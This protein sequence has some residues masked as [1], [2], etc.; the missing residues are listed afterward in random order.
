MKK[1]SIYILI[2]VFLFSGIFNV[3]AYAGEDI[4]NLE[5]DVS[6][7]EITAYVGDEDNNAVNP[8][9]TNI[10]TDDEMILYTENVN[11]DA[12]R[13][14][15]IN[16]SEDET[17]EDTL[18]L[19]PN[20][21][22]FLDMW[23]IYNSL[24]KFDY[25]NGTWNSYE[26]RI[27]TIISQYGEPD[28]EQYRTDA[29]DITDTELNNVTTYYNRLALIPDLTYTPVNLEDGYYL[30]PLI[31]SSSG[32]TI[33]DHFST[34]MLQK[35]ALVR[36]H[37]GEVFVTLRIG[38]ADCVAGVYVG[39]QAC[40]RLAKGNRTPNLGDANI[41]EG[42]DADIYEAWRAAGH[43][44]SAN[45]VYWNRNVTT[46]ADTTLS[47][48]DATFQLDNVAE[49]IIVRYLPTISK[50]SMA[51]DLQ[52]YI[53]FDEANIVRLPDI[54]SLENG[55]DTWGFD[56]SNSSM[57]T[58]SA[59]YNG[60][61][62]SDSVKQSVKSYF[63]ENISVTI[64]EDTIEANFQWADISNISY[65]KEKIHGGGSATRYNLNGDFPTDYQD[66]TINEDGTSTLI[67]PKDYKSLVFGKQML[68]H[69]T[70]LAASRNYVYALY[71][72]PTSA[73]PV[74][75]KDVTTGIEFRTDTYNIAAGSKLKVREVLAGESN[76]ERAAQYFDNV[77]RN[78][79]SW[80]I[81]V[82]D[83]TDK[84][85]IVKS[86]GKLAFP[87]PDGWN[88]EYLRL[89]YY[90]TGHA[91]VYSPGMVEGGYF[92]TET[93]VKDSSVTTNNTGH[94][95]LMEE[96]VYV[97]G[98]NL[99]DGTYAVDV[100]TWHRTSDS[101]SMSNEAIKNPS[102]LVV[103]N[104]VHTLYLS[105]GAVQETTLN[106]Y[107]SH[108]WYYGEGSTVDAN[109][110][111]QGELI[112][113]K[114]SEYYKD[115]NSDYVYDDV[116]GRI[117]YHPKEVYYTLPTT[118][119]ESYVRFQV[120]IMDMIAGGTPAPQDARLRIDYGAAMKVSDA[121]PEP[122]AEE[123]IQV[124][125]ANKATLKSALDT[126]KAVTKGNKTESAWTAL[127]TAIAEAQAVYSS[128]NAPQSQVNTAVSNLNAA[129]KAFS[130]SADATKNLDKDKLADGAYTLTATMYQ[131]D[132]KTLSMSNNAIDLP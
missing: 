24:N 118:N 30:L 88:T 121:T 68:V 44:D 93:K 117:A 76:Y 113:V 4:D 78:W 94:W 106:G 87:I 98:D 48:I 29:T 128:A 9:G 105:F 35:T 10:L 18:A 47:H 84:E 6:D 102:K 65:F 123:I 40:Y 110:Y 20:K 25:T 28:S 11:N 90:S 63:N 96:K 109:G 27:N 39:T 15:N 91:Y 45:N 34:Y 41:P 92:V 125:P 55:E 51:Y 132:R 22:T 108:M 122:P 81:A 37:G 53:D 73:E 97:N 115:E 64:K 50:T 72:C 119:W 32:T 74:I 1:L 112:P 80:D 101:Y 33:A 60:G 89:A 2:A 103:K 130:A 111:P 43:L 124:A 114:V 8:F 23:A 99:T 17:T 95:V 19:S 12:S 36:V 49:N 107:L 7:D 131:L 62:H 127:Q 38:G 71:L 67:F 13:T 75:A 54:E 46:E 57:T 100:V 116:N 26:T 126:A 82:T 86:A 59:S 58:A 120:P 21:K 5:L 83:V 69:P 31:S 16:I 77:V 104:G 56:V 70:A 14:F 42:L 66:V 3:A 61:A 79:Q 129:V 85:L 52:A